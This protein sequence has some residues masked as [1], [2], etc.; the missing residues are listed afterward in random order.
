MTE[1]NHEG[2]YLDL[3]LN[4]GDR[5]RHR[6][7]VK[8]QCNT[9]VELYDYIVQDLINQ[10]TPIER[11]FNYEIQ[12]IN[13]DYN[14]VIPTYNDRGNHID[15]VGI[16]V[17][18][19]GNDT[20]SLENVIEVDLT[21]KY[22][23]DIKV[24]TEVL[25]EKID[26]RRALEDWRNATAAYANL[27]YKDKIQ[28]YYRYKLQVIIDKLESFKPDFK[29]DTIKFVKDRIKNPKLFC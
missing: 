20:N 2:E 22:K 17:E 7:Y 27:R 18:L 15:R 26:L 9:A 19:D 29:G 1:D 11:D 16:T 5:E 4:E 6:V 21:K 3:T 14:N 10:L 28:I 24:S 8:T 12:A 23:K 13:P 25:Q